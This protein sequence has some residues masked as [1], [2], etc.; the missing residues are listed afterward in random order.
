MQLHKLEKLQEKVTL[1]SITHPSLLDGNSHL[2]DA[3]LT[4]V[5]PKSFK[6]KID[7]EL[8]LRLQH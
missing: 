6:K 2:M 8:D 3:S 5:Q 1:K 7:V 4:K